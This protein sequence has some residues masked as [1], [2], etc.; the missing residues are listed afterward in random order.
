MRYA[1]CVCQV[2]FSYLVPGDHTNLFDLSFLFGSFSIIWYSLHIY[3][4]CTVGVL[5]SYLLHIYSL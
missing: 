2:V 1:S 4:D 5:F 3:L